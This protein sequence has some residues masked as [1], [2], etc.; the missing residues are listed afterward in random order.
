[1]S[2]VYKVR[3]NNYVLIFDITREN[4]YVQFGQLLLRTPSLCFFRCLPDTR[5]IDRA[6]CRGDVAGSLALP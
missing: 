3:I 5:Q 6:R 4:S 1:M 2:E